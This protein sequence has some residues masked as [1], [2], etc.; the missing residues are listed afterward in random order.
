MNKLPKLLPTRGLDCRCWQQGIAG[1]LS[2]DVGSSGYPVHTYSLSVCHQPTMDK[3]VKIVNV[4]LFEN[5]T[6]KRR[7]ASFAMKHSL[8]H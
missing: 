3:A 6:G 8:L 4:L 7:T 1:V 2:A 5:L